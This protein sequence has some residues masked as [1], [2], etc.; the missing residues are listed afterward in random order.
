MTSELQRSR[1]HLVSAREEERRRLRRDLHDG[2][3]PTLASIAMQ[4]DAGRNL[5]VSDPQGAPRCWPKCVTRPRERS[6]T[7][8]AWS[9]GC[10][11]RR[12]T[13]SS[14]EGDRDPRSELRE[15]RRRAGRGPALDRGRCAGPAAA[16]SAAVEVAA[17]RIAEEALTNIA[18]HASARRARVSLSLDGG[19][20]LEARRRDDGRGVNGKPPRRR[21]TRC[22]KRAEELGGRC[23]VTPASA[24]AR[25]Y[26]PACR[27]P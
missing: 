24:A 21:S 14:R 15:R 11:P 5:M 6:A 4:L 13:N 25:S 27:C 16:A 7:C 10:G 9:T 26:G 8:A 23:T 1:E 2:L 20:V 18:R 19:K 17:Y 22:A 3:G 12:W